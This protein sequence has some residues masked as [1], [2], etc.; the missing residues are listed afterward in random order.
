M[1]VATCLV[2]SLTWTGISLLIFLLWRI[3]RF[4]EHSSGQRA[5]SY[6]F[7]L[8]LLLLLAGAVYYIL[9]DVD[10]IGSTTASLLL[11]FGG[12]LL[13]IATILLGQVM[14]VDR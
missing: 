8:S 1:T 10:F 9:F 3:A 5:Y 4:Y 2:A 7:L 13:G 11:F 6:L 14:G 12:T